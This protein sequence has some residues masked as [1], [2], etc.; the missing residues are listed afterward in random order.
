ME[1]LQLIFGIKPL[2]FFPNS[3]NVLAVVVKV[4]HYNY[5]DRS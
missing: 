1:T 3:A 2:D 4:K 5:N